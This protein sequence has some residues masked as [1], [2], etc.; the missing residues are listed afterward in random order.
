[1]EPGGILDGLR[2]ASTAGIVELSTLEEDLLG[3]QLCGERELELAE[4]DE[5]S[6]GE[7]IAAQL[8]QV[9]LVITTG[10]SATGSGLVDRLRGIGTARIDGIHRLR[11][12]DLNSRCHDATAAE[13][14]ANPLGA[15]RA[16]TSDVLSEPHSHPQDRSWTLILHAERSIHPERL[17][18]HI[19]RL[20]VGRARS[21]GIFHVPNRPDSACLWDGAGGQ[22]CIAD[23]G[24]WDE[25]APGRTQQTRLCF[26]GAG[27]FDEGAALRE[28][29][30][31]AFADVLTRPQEISDGGL[32]WLGCVDVLAPWLGD[33]AP[34]SSQA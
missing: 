23:L 19:E 4:D 9:D 17:L 10:R 33:R 5:R 2:L 29:L 32:A 3:E 6:I 7:A 11:L 16:H 31:N 25:C 22:L 20:G 8:E 14:R 34:T 27:T 30:S 21:R 13:A 12:A 18:E 28:N 15:C 1:M 26:V 24:E